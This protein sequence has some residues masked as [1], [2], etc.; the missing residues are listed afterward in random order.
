LANPA[1]AFKIGAA[2][3][4]APATGI[5]LAAPRKAIEFPVARN[6]LPAGIFFGMRWMILPGIMLAAFFFACDVFNL[7]MSSCA[8]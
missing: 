3:Q 7:A 2:V 8:I 1:A 5:D 4:T 6:A